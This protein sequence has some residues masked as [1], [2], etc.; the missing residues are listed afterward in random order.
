MTLENIPDFLK[1]CKS[2]P[3]WQKV[4]IGQHHGIVLSLASLRSKQSSGI[5]EFFD[6]LPLIDW[7]QELGLDLL[8]LLPLNDTA[9]E[10]SPYF[11]ISSC[12][13]NPIY[14]SLSSLSD[15]GEKNL[16]KGKKQL[17]KLSSLERVPYKKV[18]EKKIQWLR[19]YFDLQKKELIHDPSLQNFASQNPFLPLYGLFLILGKEKNSYDWQ[20]WD[21]KDL[22]QEKIEPLLE[23]HK[24]ELYFIYFLQFLAFSQM[25]SVK[26]YAT[27][28]KVQLLGDLPILISP[29]SADVFWHQD[30]FNLNYSAGAPPDAFNPKGQKW[31]FPL[32]DWEGMK[33]D[34][35]SWWKERLKVAA[36]FYHLYRIDHI[37]GFFRIW[38]IAHGKRASSGFFLP[39]ERSLW[40]KSGEEHL[41]K[42][43]ELS[44]ILPVGEDLGIIPQET[45]DTLKELGICGTRVMRWLPDKKPE[46][47]DPL[48]ITT[49]STHDTETLQEWWQNHPNE[50]SLLA[51][52]NHWTYEPKLRYDERKRLLIDAHRTK[53]LF[54]INLLQEYLALF[55][56]LVWDS[57][58]KERIN[59]PGKILKSNWCYRFRLPLEELLAHEGLKKAFREILSE[60]KG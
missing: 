54:H 42:L 36:Q 46:E 15:L 11:A 30:L 4:G 58:E 59:I 48:S 17:E 47:Y 1:S 18:Y 33:K 6:L 5:G 3:L 51:Q 27:Q 13:L 50:S 2:Y 8:Q 37:V 39:Q 57:A 26:E 53:S 23:K 44:S 43:L 25:R 35:F 16:I 24:E 9:L 56:D 22:S 41:S 60:A 40:K 45:F 12:A 32:Y 29:H 52:K 7:C 28:K 31:N 38:A 19:A 14:L 20:T 21:L 34:H 10:S 55:E 49:L